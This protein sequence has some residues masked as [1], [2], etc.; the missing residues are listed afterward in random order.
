M[1]KKPHGVRGM[2]RV[3]VVVL[4]IM[5]ILL[6]GFIFPALILRRPNPVPRMC[7]VHLSGLGKAMLIY[8]NDYNDRLP[9]AGGPNSVWAARVPNWRADTAEEAY[10]IEPNNP[11]R[12]SISAGLYL[13]IKYEEVEPKA[14]VCPF[15]QGVAEFKPKKY[16]IRDKELIDLWDFGPEPP[17][18]VSYAFYQPHGGPIPTV[19]SP[20]ALAIAADR[21]PWM[22]SPFVKARSF[23]EFEPDI[24]PFGGTQEQALRGNAIAHKGDGQNV[25]FLDSHVEFSKRSYCGL[26]DDNIYTSWDGTDKIRGRPARFGSV[27][28]DPDDSLLVNDPAVAPGG[29]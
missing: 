20:S 16:G 2:T 29:P 21:N 26:D 15:D 19:K 14:F 12:A 23:A 17:K 7:G 3:E 18:H 1:T 4:V 22:D 11:G 27:P 6:L 13:L 25:L 24:A 28:A 10:G 8:A 9:Y 5:L